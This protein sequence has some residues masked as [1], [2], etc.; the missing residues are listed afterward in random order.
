MISYL[1]AESKG[2]VIG[3]DGNL[4]WKLPADMHYF[5]QTTTNNI[6]LAGSKTYKSFGRPLPHRLNV[7]LTHQED[8]RFPDEVMVIHNVNDFLQF[9]NNNKEKEIFV[10]GGAQ[11]FKLLLPYVDRLYRTSIDY[12]FDGD[13]VMPKINY[14]EFNLIKETIGKLDSKNIYP[15]KFDVFERK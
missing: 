15:H 10:V 14:D 8:N 12:K 6:I 5:K 9:A 3:M 11:I 4:P 7:V 1:W 2:H 13:T